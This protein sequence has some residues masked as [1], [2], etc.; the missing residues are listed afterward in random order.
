M[1]FK[2]FLFFFSLCSISFF[3]VFSQNKTK[4]LEKKID[5]H[6]KGDSQI[7]VGNPYVGIEMHHSSFLP[8][9]ISFYYPVANSIDMSADYFKRDTTFIMALGLKIGDEKKQWI[10]LKPTPYIL[11]PYS[12][13]FNDDNNERNISVSYEFCKTKP[14]MVIKY[15]ILNK[16]KTTK[17]FEFYSHLETSL[18]TSHTY[19]LID[20][21]W[22]EY[23]PSTG[24]I[25][26]NYEN[27]GAQNA[28]VFVSNAGLLPESFSSEGSMDYSSHP[29]NDHWFDHAGNLDGKTFSSEKQ[30]IPAAVFLYKKNLK[31]GEAMTIIQIVGSSKQSEGKE[32]VNY[33]QKNY[34]TEINDYEDYVLSQVMNGKFLTNDKSLD[35]SYLWAKAILAVDKHYIDGQI[36]PMP[37]PA[38]YNFYFTHDVM[39][40]DLAAVNF[41]LPR[42][43]DD[44]LYTIEHANSDYVIPHAYYWKDS[45]YTTEY[46]ESDN[47]NHFWFIINAASYLRHSGDLA[48]L[49]KLYPYL[50]KSLNLSLENR[51]EG[52]MWEIRPDWWDIGH[53]YGPRAYTTILEIKTLRD[54]IYISSMLNKNISKLED[55]EN[56]TT[57]LNKNL[58]DKLWDNKLN[59]L[60]NYYNQGGEDTHYYIGSLLAAHFNLLDK[61]YLNK[62]V[63]SAKGKLLD[64][65]VGVYDVFPMDFE[66][67][68]SIWKFLDNEEGAPYY[69][70]NGGIWPH[71]N[72]WYALSLIADN[73]KDEAYNFIKKVMTIDGVMNS[74]NGQPAMYEVRIGDPHN[75]KIYGTIDKPEFMW[76]GAWYIYSL[77][78]LFGI[79]E[80]DWNIQ[81]NPYLNKLNRSA[82]FTLTANGQE[83]NVNITGKGNYV[84]S[85]SYGGAELPTLVIPSE[86]KNIKNVNI[87]LGDVSS[88]YIKSTNALLSVCSYDKITKKISFALKA[89]SNYNSK[90]EIISRGK[91]VEIFVDGKLYENWSAM[92][93]GRNYLT[94]ID[95]KI[96]RDGNNLQV[97]F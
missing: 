28:Q 59:Y 3:N 26:S 8:E 75:P 97:E 89:F 23:D 49:E 51:K 31:P 40:T 41:D 91:P 20:K 9:R 17:P 13:K 83:F 73:K 19:A 52:L 90:T 70:I 74:P 33:L 46:A 77:Y 15:V 96:K 76:A 95:V 34:Q 82:D 65:K 64:P 48:T 66:K 45:S 38:E 79:Q 68:N 81:L 36:R 71:G 18:K 30:G 2:I 43:K 42:V 88:P 87:I 54:Y 85:I 24:T 21:A 7:E 1:K 25:Y 56:I 57:S 62:L 78:H 12:V 67:L 29:L 44:L 6:F 80:N 50:T 84:K 39:L 32:I 16:S 27:E 58:V 55:Y 4:E 72:S 86:I 63:T 11:N 22:T 37:C 14:A 5:V 60:M 47:W 35:H 61:K 92:K 53:N 94:T 93:N 10:G 69:Y